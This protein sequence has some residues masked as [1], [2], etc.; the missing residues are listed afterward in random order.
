[1]TALGDLMDHEAVHDDRDLIAWY[2]RA[3][4]T[5]TQ[6]HT[7][8]WRTLRDATWDIPWTRL[9]V[10]ARYL[11]LDTIYHPN[12]GK[13]VECEAGD[14]GASAVWRCETTVWKHGAA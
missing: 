5:R 4:H 13:Y 14:A 10:V 12:D 7:R 11:R 9:R 3:S 2:P 8:F 1:M 6:A